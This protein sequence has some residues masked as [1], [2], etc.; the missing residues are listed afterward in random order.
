MQQHRQTPRLLYATIV[1]VARVAVQAAVR[2]DAILAAV[3]RA[4]RA[5]ALS[6][7]RQRLR[8]VAWPA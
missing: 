8:C 3:A 6:S 4:P 2:A 5:S 1:A 7:S